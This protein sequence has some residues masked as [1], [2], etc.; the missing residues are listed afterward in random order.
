MTQNANILSKSA[1]YANARKILGDHRKVFESVAD[2][3]AAL[4]AIYATEG[5]PQSFPVVAARLGLVDV[6]GDDAIPPLADWPEEFR[7]EGVKVAVTFI[8]VRGLGDKKDQNGA[9]GFAVYPLHPLD[10]IQSDDSGIAWLWKVAEKE[11][12]HVALRGL[13][14]VNPAFG[15]DALHNAAMEMPISV[16]DYVEESTRESMDTTAFDTLWKQFRKMLSESPAT[17]ALVA[18]LPAKAE[19]LKAIRSKAYAEETYPELESMGSFKWMA[20]TMAAIIDQMRGAA[21]ESGE[22]FEL[23]SDEIKGWLATRD[24]KVFA[25]PKKIEGDL[26]TVD[27]GSFMA[28][29]APAGNGSEEGAGET[30]E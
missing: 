13:R 19:V 6:T 12:S 3:L 11:S 26:S 1:E 30:G 5:F 10:A 4:K 20:G 17:A 16:S 23:D 21:I 27:F 28:G 14:N 18:R 25:A 15:S 29:L 8:G 24:T 7:S 9:R 22:D 2:A